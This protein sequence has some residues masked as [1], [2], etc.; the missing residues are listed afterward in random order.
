MS[1]QILVPLLIAT[2]GALFLLLGIVWL[3]GGY[4]SERAMSRITKATYALLT[5][6]VAMIG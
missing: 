2:P 3:L 6:L 5:V 4:V 1:L